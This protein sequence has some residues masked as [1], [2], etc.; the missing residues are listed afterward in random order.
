MKRK[1]E[2]KINMQSFV[3]DRL[4]SHTLSMQTRVTLVF[5]EVRNISSQFDAKFFVIHFVFARTSIHQQHLHTHN[6]Y[7]CSAHG[8]HKRFK[9]AQNVKHRRQVKFVVM[10]TTFGAFISTAANHKIYL[11][12]NVHRLFIKNHRLD[13][14]KK[15]HTQINTL[16]VTHGQE[17]RQPK[18]VCEWK[19]EREIWAVLCCVG[20]LFTQQWV[21]SKSTSD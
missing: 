19:R 13:E 5:C 10:N 17:M 20:V 2:V 8:I 11:T 12:L 21:F 15:K 6:T 18:R 9:H 16:T 4:N 1:R 14:A 7:T 3:F